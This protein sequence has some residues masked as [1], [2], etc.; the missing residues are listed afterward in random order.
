MIDGAAPVLR[1]NL[2]EWRRYAEGGF[3]AAFASVSTF[4][5]MPGTIAT[6]S[7]FHRLIRNKPDEL[8]LVETIKDIHDAHTEN[9]LGIVLAFQD[10]RALGQD[11]GLVDIYAKLGVRSVNLC[12]NSRNLLGDGCLEP[13][14]SGLSKLGGQMVS[15]LN[16]TGILLDLA[17][18]GEQTTLE[19]MERSI[20]PDAFTHANARSVYDHPRNLTDQQIKMV[21]E[22]GGIVG[23]CSCPYFI[24][25]KTDRPTI[26]DLIV[27]LEYIIDLV[28]IDHVGL[29]I[30][31]YHGTSYQERV[32]AGIWNPDDY[33]P[34][35]WHFPLDGTNTV[36]FVQKLLQRGYGKKNI[37]KILAGNFIRVLSQVWKD[38]A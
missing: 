27:H 4:Q 15:R 7:T 33:P 26:D 1:E 32:E 21:A 31:F 22:K 29:G 2:G 8:K 12:Y 23:V 24:T 19:A 28:G 20:L 17:H 30:D 35:P 5:E 13:A 38:R 6:L 14:N 34:P 36:L 16:D 37:Q 18:S 25:N 11:V 9:K 3:T 10:G